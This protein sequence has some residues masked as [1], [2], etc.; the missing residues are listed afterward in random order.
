MQAT[1]AVLAL[2]RLRA[3]VQRHFGRPVGTAFII[4]TT[5]QFHLPFYMSR[6]LP[7]TFA[8]ILMSL[9]FADWLSRRADSAIC[10]L[11]FTT[12]IPAETKAVHCGVLLWNGLH[13]VF[14]GKLKR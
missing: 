4:F 10:L 8:L 3:A 1:F 2:S 6:P 5:V 12:V 14:S 13:K 11:V 7:N 9:A